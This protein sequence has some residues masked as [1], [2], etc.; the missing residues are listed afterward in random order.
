MH[1]ELEVDFYMRILQINTERTWRGGER[2]T[3][4]TALGMRDAGHDVELLAH[5]D[6]V[7]AARAAEQGL[8][9]HCASN[10]SEF[11]FWLARQGCRYDIVHAQTAQAATW[12]VLTKWL[13]RRP[14]V[15]TRRTN[16]PSG[17]KPWV[18][19]MKWSR[20]DQM[21]AIS[22]AAAVAPRGMGIDTLIIPS[23]VPPVV[24]DAMR[25]QT[26]IEEQSLQGLRV[27]GTASALSPEKDPVTLIRAASLV[28]ERFDD[29]VFVHWGASGQASEDAQQC[30][31]DLNLGS[32]YRLLGF[33][34]AVEQ[35][36]PALSVFVMASRFEALGTSVLDAM[37]QRVPVVAT[38][39]GGLKE[40]LANHR[41]LM[42]PVGDARAM[43][44]QIITLLEQPARAVAM[45]EAAC[46]DVIREYDVGHMTQR[47]L[48]VYA[49]LL[50]RRA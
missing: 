7:L 25:V 17:S 28:C 23:A 1:P 2:Q 43:A 46:E 19:R 10:S 29:V 14:V 22:E 47:Y 38:D 50:T 4:L 5:G 11:A 18:T 33:E 34:T 26:F 13:H 21:V 24:A 6:G 12:T 36:Y 8:R 31:R 48:D 35:L 49:G 39:A 16:F 30:M 42:C 32:R 44:E 3:L 45:A 27:V 40:T 37:M 15:F 20:V 41:G 9:V